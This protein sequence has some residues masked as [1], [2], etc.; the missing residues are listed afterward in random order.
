MSDTSNGYGIPSVTDRLSALRGTSQQQQPPATSSSPRRMRKEILIG[1][2]VATA[3]IALALFL[4]GGSTPDSLVTKV[5]SVV[6]G[7]APVDAPSQLM[8]GEA[9]VPISVESGNLPPVLSVGDRVRVIVTPDQNGTG[10]VRGL[11]D[12]TVVHDIE[13]PGDIGTRFVVTVRAPEGVAAAIA[14][15]GPVFLAIISKEGQ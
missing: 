2:L 7:T 14:A 1:A 15:S 5:N 11:E 4:R 3:G 12:T 10:T 8:S 9:F 6:E 13:T